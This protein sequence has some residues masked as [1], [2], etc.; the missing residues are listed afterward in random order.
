MRAFGLLVVASFVVGCGRLGFDAQTRVADAPLSDTSGTDGIDPDALVASRC[1][2]TTTLVCDGFEGNALD[3]RWQLDV[4]LGTV[5]TSATRAYRGAGSVHV[6][7]D[8][9]TAAVTNPR[10]LLQTSQ[11]LNATVVGTVY[12]RVWAYFAS[13]HH[14]AF[15]D[16]IV[17]FA[18]TA[19]NGISMGAR[20]GAIAS[21][22][23][24]AIQFAESTTTSLP[25]DRWTCLQL[26]IP[27]GT[28]GTT[29]VSI[30]GVEV[31]DV[32]LTKA[33]V[34]PSPDHVY[35][36]IEW[37]GTVSNVPAANAWIDEVVIDSAPTTCAD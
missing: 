25:L 31:V 4:N 34:Q 7:M 9:I 17:N 37:V 22:D 1:P 21:N 12:A 33:T 6:H 27:A 26:E 35:I 3:P 11:R 18:N 13:P 24:T 16:Q 29:K 14:P 28:S 20:N 36:G 2:K 19:G 15:F 23:Y 8:A 5:A 30:D 10:A 32:R